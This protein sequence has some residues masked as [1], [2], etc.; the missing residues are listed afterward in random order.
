[1]RRPDG[2]V[3]Y[4][5]KLR[6]EDTVSTQVFLATN[7]ALLAEDLSGWEKENYEVVQIE[8]LGEPVVLE[9]IKVHRDPASG[10]N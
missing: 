1:M 6:K 10:L 7:F 2:I 5:V 4:T 8:R 3:V 9:P